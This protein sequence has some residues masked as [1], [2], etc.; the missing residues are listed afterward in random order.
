[1]TVAKTIAQVKSELKQEIDV[2]TASFATHQEGGF[3]LTE[4]ASFTFDV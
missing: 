1:M 2:L 4:I 3:Q